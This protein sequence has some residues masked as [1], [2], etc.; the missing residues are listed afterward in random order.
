MSISK[1]SQG[2]ANTGDKANKVQ[3][4]FPSQAQASSKLIGAGPRRKPSIWPRILPEKPCVK[5][6]SQ[7]SMQQK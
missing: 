2:T 6:S 3:S 5:L 1:N 4:E 7:V